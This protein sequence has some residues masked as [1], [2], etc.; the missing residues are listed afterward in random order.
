MERGFDNLA[1]HLTDIKDMVID[2]NEWYEEM[3]YDEGSGSNPSGVFDINDEMPSNTDDSDRKRGKGYGVSKRKADIRKS[4]IKHFD[5]TKDLILGAGSIKTRSPG[6]MKS[7]MP[8]ANQS[9]QE[10]K[11]RTSIQVPGSGFP[12]DLSP[13]P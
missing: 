9:P 11:S 7:V 3:F 12:K 5:Q 6:K 13:P 8:L 2:Q 10:F 1:G 4:N